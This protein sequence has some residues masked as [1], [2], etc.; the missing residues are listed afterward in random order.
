MP[1]QAEY[2]TNMVMDL[3]DICQWADTKRPELIQIEASVYGI[4]RSERSSVGQVDVNVRRRCSGR[5]VSWG[6]Y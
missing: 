5:G 6:L 2:R 1:G 4:G 3:E